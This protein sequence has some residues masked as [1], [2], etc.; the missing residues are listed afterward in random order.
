MSDVD[1]LIIQR[2]K[3]PTDT[4]AN[5]VRPA[6]IPF[7]PHPKM[8]ICLERKKGGHTEKERSI[9]HPISAVDIAHMQFRTFS[10][11]VFLS[12]IVCVAFFFTKKI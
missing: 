5:V 12:F 4:P 2:T 10:G 8:R 1:L 7:S 3:Y 9:Q 11:G 6:D